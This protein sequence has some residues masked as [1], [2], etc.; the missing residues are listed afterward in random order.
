MQAALAEIAEISHGYS[1]RGRIEADPDGDVLVIQPKDLGEDGAVDFS[2]AIRK[3]D[4]PIRSSFLLRAGDVLFQPRGV[5]YRAAL[6]GNLAW[7]AIAAAPVYV[8]RPDPARVR[9]PYLAAFL[10]DPQT[11]TLLR[12]AATGTHVP[13]VARGALE[14]LEIPLPALA[15]QDAL[16][17]LARLV[18]H[19]KKIE[20]ALNIR[21]LALVRALA[22]ARAAG[23][24]PIAAH[25]SIRRAQKAI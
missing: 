20:D 8:V 7:P 10:N 17:E 23:T 16:G 22:R 21:M 14:A 24:Q 5:T 19:K 1:F 13:Q 15:D 25:E 6:V 3:S 4:V 18:I 9:A 11:Q 2:Q 12:Q